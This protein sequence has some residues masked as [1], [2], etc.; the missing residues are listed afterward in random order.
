MNLRKNT[1][2]ISRLL[3]CNRKYFTAETL[4]NNPLALT[5]F[6]WSVMLDR[7]KAF[8]A[9]TQFISLKKT[10]NQRN[11]S[12]LKQTVGYLHNWL[13]RIEV[14]FC[15]ESILYHCGLT[16]FFTDKASFVYLW[17]HE[18]GAFSIKKNKQSKAKG[19]PCEAISPWAPVNLLTALLLANAAS[20]I[21]ASRS[22]PYEIKMDLKLKRY[23]I[24]LKC[25]LPNVPKCIL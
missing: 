10:W 23:K 6:V 22:K 2:V 9:K 5:G 21:P 4:I 24:E 20:F 19:G 25:L 3:F 18:G 15:F 14:I 17:S 7:H 11:K 1:V 13:Y 16:L 12:D 8:Q